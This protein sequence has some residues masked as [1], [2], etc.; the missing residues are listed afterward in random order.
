MSSKL[1]LHSSVLVKLMTSM[2]TFE[3]RLVQRPNCISSLIL[4]VDMRTTFLLRDCYRAPGTRTRDENLMQ[5]LLRT[6]YFLFLSSTQLL[7]EFLACLSLM[8]RPLIDMKHVSAEHFS[9]TILG[10][11]P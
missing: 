3:D 10:S 7:L 6:C 11:W 2:R 9:Q 4:T 8:P 5:V 1:C